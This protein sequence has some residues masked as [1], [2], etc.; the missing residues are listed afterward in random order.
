MGWQAV[1]SKLHFIHFMGLSEQFA[2]GRTKRAQVESTRL[3]TIL[4]F[5]ATGNAISSRS[6]LKCICNALCYS[7][8]EETITRD[9]YLPLISL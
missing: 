2:E 5:A 8:S 6:P 3:S 9:I 4:G 7:I 1:A